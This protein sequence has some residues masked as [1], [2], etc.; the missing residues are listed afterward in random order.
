MTEFL[1]NISG[2]QKK[3]SSM[4]QSQMTGLESL[5]SQTGDSITSM[6][7]AEHGK[8]ECFT[9]DFVVKETT[10]LEGQLSTLRDRIKD[11]GHGF[12]AQV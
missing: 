7:E 12:N 4:V 10:A 1:R 3:A 6:C 5:N 2:F 11:L 8:I 9:Q